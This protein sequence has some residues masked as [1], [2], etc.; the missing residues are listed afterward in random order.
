MIEPKLADAMR[1]SDD[2]Q[3]RLDRI[4]ALDAYLQQEVETRRK[5]AIK[6]QRALNAAH[7]VAVG[8]GFVGLGL[9]G[10]G[11]CLLATG[12]GALPGIA[13]SGI[14][15]GAIC[16]DLA[17]GM[18]NSKLA[19]KL[20]KHRAIEQ[21]ARTKLNTIH[22][23]VS[24]ALVDSKISDDEY[25]L[26]SDEVEKYD[27]LK[28]SIRN[29]SYAAKDEDVLKKQWLRTEFEKYMRGFSPSPSS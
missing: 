23:L 12:F 4:G 18:V 22:K 5:L 25:K 19:R 10:A 16:I 21:C 27:Q 13:L 1:Q 17:C 26:V 3:F 11:V 24:T 15:A 20:D 28:E 29:K 14:G 9:E 8:T 7:S 6:Y 2:Q